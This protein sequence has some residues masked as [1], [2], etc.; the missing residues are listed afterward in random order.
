MKPYL[1]KIKS[2]QIHNSAIVESKNIGKDVFIGPFCLIGPNVILQEGV[3][4][5]SHVVINGNT[6]IGKVENKVSF[7]F[8]HF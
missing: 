5:H 6:K 8:F 3:N 7:F 4:L 2:K 1:Q